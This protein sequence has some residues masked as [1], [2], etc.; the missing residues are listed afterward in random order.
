MKDKKIQVKKEQILKAFGRGEISDNIK[1]LLFKDGE[2]L[3]TPF[4]TKISTIGGGWFHI[5]SYSWD[6]SDM[7]RTLE[8]IYG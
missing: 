1:A 3:C 6:G 5:G 4:G 7:T 8:A 2:T